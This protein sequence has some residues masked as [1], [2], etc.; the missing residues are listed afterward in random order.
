VQCLEGDLKAVDEIVASDIVFNDPASPVE[1][2]GI[3]SLR[4]YLAL[5]RTAFP[6]LHF[7]IEQIWQ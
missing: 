6:D 3:E 1:V 4:Q 5:F 7:T 2:R